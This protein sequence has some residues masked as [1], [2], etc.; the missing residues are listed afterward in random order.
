M[1]ELT[2]LKELILIKKCTKVMIFVTK[3]FNFQQDVCNGCHDVSM[4]SI[5]FNDIAILYIRSVHYRCIIN[6]IGDSEAIN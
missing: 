1:I 4:I 3:G 2:F 5:N 6:G